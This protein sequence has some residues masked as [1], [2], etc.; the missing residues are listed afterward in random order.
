MKVNVGVKREEAI[1][2]LEILKEKGMTYNPPLKA[3][4]SGEDIGIFSNLGKG[5]E[6]V[7]YAL[8]LNTGD[9]GFYDDLRNAVNE[10]E[11][12]HNAVVYLILVT[13]TIFQTLCDMFYVSDCKE[14]WE[15]D[16]K[17]LR[18]GWSCTYSYNQTE[19]LFSEIGDIAFSASKSY[20]GLYR[21]E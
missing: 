4:K 8:N 3:F 2:R 16:R 13:H 11:A 12:K 10:F 17:D 7:Y 19:P 15:R 18:E 20:G 14:E 21:T 1:K 9:E 5:A 6:A